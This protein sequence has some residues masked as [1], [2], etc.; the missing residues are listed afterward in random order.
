MPSRWAPSRSVVSYTWKASPSGVP[1][2]SV[3][4][5]D[6]LLVDLAGQTKRPPADAR[7]LRVGRVWL[8]DAPA[9]NKG[10]GVRHG[11]SL[12][13]RF[14][15]VTRASHILGR[16]CSPRGRSTRHGTSPR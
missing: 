10:A 11:A 14:R 16:A 5:I 2:G 9:D 13:R 15:E 4:D 7:G 8:A 6:W 12:A 1:A 3:R